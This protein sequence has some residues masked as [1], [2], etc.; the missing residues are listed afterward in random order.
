MKNSIEEKLL[1][2]AEQQKKLID[3]YQAEKQKNDE[4]TG[5]VDTLMGDIE[6]ILPKEEEA[7]EAIT[8][9]PS[10]IPN[11]QPRIMVNGANS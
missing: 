7:P 1:G 11:G 9:N 8:P 10:G 3:L 2:L 4:L 5:I 6:K